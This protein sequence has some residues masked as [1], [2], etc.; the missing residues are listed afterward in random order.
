MT[1][2]TNKKQRDINTKIPDIK[3]VRVLS[4]L[5]GKLHLP[6]CYSKYRSVE[7]EYDEYGK[8]LGTVEKDV[9][10]YGFGL[11]E[12]K[13]FVERWFEY[14]KSPAPPPPIKQVPPWMPY[15]RD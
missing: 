13:A 1:S 3:A 8:F 2:S 14:V 11:A 10:A 15:P 9:E 7:P 6:S 5:L 12:A 4:R